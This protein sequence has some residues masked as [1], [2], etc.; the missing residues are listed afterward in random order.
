MS[1][2]EK[3]LIRLK[4]EITLL[5]VMVSVLALITACNKE[6]DKLDLGED[7]PV[8]LYHSVVE[9]LEEGQSRSMYVSEENFEKDLNYLKDKGYETI[10]LRD[11]ESYYRGEDVELPKK[12]I[13][14]TFDDGYLNN[15]ENAYPILKEYDM[16]A[17][18]YMI[19]WSVGRDT[20][21]DSDK[22]IT[23]HYNWDQAREMYDSG[24]IE[25]GSHT[26]DLHNEPGLSYGYKNQVGLGLAMMEGEN[27]E[28]YRERI[29][30]DLERSKLMIEEEVG[31]EVTSIAYPYGEY[32]DILLDMLEDLG[33]RSGLIT[34]SDEGSKSPF[35]IRRQI[36]TED[37]R[38]SHIF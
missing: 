34:E 1:I 4:K 27:E 26:F 2:K 29:R 10:S 11:M 5:V 21:I 8:L 35:A 32:N 28:D 6:K 9:E 30:L 37:R 24:L 13:V 16:K 3:G 19:G 7:I 31:Q 17:V 36:I 20:F 38:V 15:Y 14:I 18:I 23:P 25:F 12:P 22:P 33:F